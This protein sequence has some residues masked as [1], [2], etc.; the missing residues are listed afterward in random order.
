MT[1]S[2]AN[3]QAAAN[4]ETVT[5]TGAALTL[6]DDENLPEVTLALSPSSIDEHDGTNP[7]S[8]T[9]TATLDRASSEAV[10][11]TVSASPGAGTDFTLSSANTLTIAAGS[12]TSAGTVTITAVNDTTDA[13]D[14]SVTVS[15]TAAGGN[16]VAPPSSVSLTIADDEGT[17]TV[18]LA[19]S[20]ASTL[21]DGRRGDGDGDAF[22]QV[23]RGR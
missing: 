14:K 19:L 4:S 2:A 8:S 11:L 1:G 23:E 10:T 20:P 15:A 6:T 12:T 9:V 3:A 17:P 18:T 5:V 7:G 13:P 16:G 22:R 21:G